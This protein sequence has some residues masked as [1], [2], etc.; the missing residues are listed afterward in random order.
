MATSFDSATFASSVTR[1][2]DGKEGSEAMALLMW[3]A[4]LDN[5]STLFN[6]DFSS[7]PQLLSPDLFNNSLYGTIP[8]HIGSLSRLIFLSLSINHL[9]GS[10]PAS[11]ANLSNL[12]SLHLYGNQLSGPIPQEIGTLASLVDLKLSGN[13]LTSTIP[14]SI[15]K[16]GN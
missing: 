8:S 4:R 16:L 14:V 6:L 10:I 12:I 15:R 5:G 9:T 1:E 3:K 11:I 13:S 2:E 7:F